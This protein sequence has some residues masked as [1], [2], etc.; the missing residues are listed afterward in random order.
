MSCKCGNS[1]LI[2]IKHR[3]VKCGRCGREYWWSPRYG[4]G[5]EISE[6]GIINED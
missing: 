6:G 3:I 5:C 2:L 1:T 4:M